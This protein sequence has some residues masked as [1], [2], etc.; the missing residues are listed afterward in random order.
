MSKQKRIR[1]LVKRVGQ[2]PVIEEI[3]NTLEAKKAIVGGW[4]QF[5][6]I[7]DGLSLWCNDDGKVNGLKPNFNWVHEGQIFDVICGD[8]YFTG[9]ADDEGYDIDIAAA[10]EAMA[11]LFIVAGQDTTFKTLYDRQGS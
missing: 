4:I 9:P 3:D 2:E 7:E 6:P 8:V 11:R 10:N 1:V 5:V